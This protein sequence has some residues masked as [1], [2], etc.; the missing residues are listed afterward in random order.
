[1]SERN[2][3]SRLKARGNNT[4]LVPNQRRVHRAATWTKVRLGDFVVMMDTIL[5][6]L[7]VCCEC[8][9]PELQESECQVMKQYVGKK[10]QQNM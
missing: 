5:L 4:R 6:R 10:R 7:C 1:M 2:P 8:D 3:L 9:V